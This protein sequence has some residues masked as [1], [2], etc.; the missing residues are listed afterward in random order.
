MSG[1][2]KHEYDE[3]IIELRESGLTCIAVAEKL[4]IAYHT[5][6]NC[7]LRLGLQGK[8]RG[9]RRDD[10]Y[11]VKRPRKPNPGNPSPFSIL[12]EGNYDFINIR[13]LPTSKEQAERLVALLEKQGGE[14]ISEN[15]L[16]LSKNA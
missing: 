6:Q 9:N 3:R 13:L 5:V 11:I 14:V 12:V 15:G 2:Y 10:K 16:N 7:M 4:D 8:F 1:Y